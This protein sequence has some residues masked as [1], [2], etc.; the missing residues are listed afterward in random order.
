M[1]DSGTAKHSLEVTMQQSPKT[2]PYRLDIQGLRAIAIAI[3][4]LAHAEVPGFAGGFVGV[5]VFFVLS[6]YLISGLLL[7]ERLSTGRLHYG[8]FLARRLRRLLPAMIAM[9]VIVM[10]LALSLLSAYEVRMQTG[11]FA[12]SATWTSNFFFALS[13]FDYFSALQARDLFLH[14][15]SLGVEEQFYV[16]WPGLIA[17][18][19]V[20]VGSSTE[21]GRHRKLLLTIFASVLV[22]SLALCLHWALFSPLLGFYMMPARGW[23]FAL[24]AIVFV[25]GHEFDASQLENPSLAASK[26]LKLPLA[27]TGILLIVG[28]AIFLSPKLT[29]PS[30]YALFPSVG[31]AL[32]ILAGGPDHSSLSRNVLVSKPFVWLGDHSYSLYLWHWPVLL[33]GGAYGMTDSVSEL[34]ALLLVSMLL[35]MLSYTFVERPW[36]KGKFSGATPAYTMLLSALVI[37]I[38]FS[39]GHSLKSTFVAEQFVSTELGNYKPRL[40]RSDIYAADKRCDTWYHSADLEPCFIG[41][42]NAEHTAVFLGDSIGTQWLPLL[43]EIYAA[44]N[45]RFIV[46]TKS[47]CAMVDEEYVYAGVG[48]PYTVCTTWRNA[49]L[50]YISIN[51]PDVVFVGS[52]SSYAFTADQWSQ[53]TA[54]ILKKLSDAAK[55]IVLIP[56]TPALSFDG[57]SCLQSPYRFSFRLDNSERECEEKQMDDTSEAVSGYLATAQSNFSNVDLL[58]LNDLVCPDKRCAAQDLNGTTIFR[59][60]R[61]LTA[62]FVTTQKSQVSERL[63]RLRIGPTFFQK[64]AD[65]SSIRIKANKRLQ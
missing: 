3:V 1:R 12:F 10:A 38:A 46:L 45:W 5:D 62:T 33:F 44:P 2:L 36:W 41:N 21:P 24:G 16:V 54:R 32:V 25:Y 58:D 28:S 31:A 64:T 11:S 35:A 20:F 47:A 48:G 7:Q 42:D 63:E 15:W 53:G 51:N 23:Q 43:L 19:F 6:G 13:E 29:Y 56:G 60:R 65:T 14:T 61:H 18:T 49:A 30:F 55:Q 27:P 26:I 59:D 17:L 4:F 50:E 8:R 52:A 34:L 57:P 40:D 22:I 39:A 9:L 37:G